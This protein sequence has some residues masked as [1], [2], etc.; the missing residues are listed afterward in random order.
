MPMNKRSIA[1]IIA[2]FFTVFTAFAVR[3]SYGML[4]PEM[5]PSLG[6]TKTQAGVIF[7]SYFVAYTVGSPVLGLL[8]DRYSV[9]FILTLFTAVLGAGTFLMAYTSS[10]LSASLFFTLAGI[11]HSACWAPVV[12]LVQRWVSDKRRGMALAFTDL[13]S[14]S[15][16]MLWSFAIPYIVSISSW[17]KGWMSLGTFAFIVALLNLL[18]I[19]NP[20]GA[21]SQAQESASV[22]PVHDSIIATYGRLLHDP[23]LW[24]LGISYLLVGF[25]VIIPFTFLCTFAT[26]ELHIAYDTST[27]LLAILAVAGMVGKLSLGYLSDIFGRA[28][29]MIICV[30]F[31]GSGCLGMAY[32]DGFFIL[33]IFTALFGLGYGSVWPIY[34]AAAPDYFPRRHSGSVIG[35][36]TLYLGAGSVVSPVLSG[37]TIDFTGTYKWAFI[38]GV[39]SA[40]ASL[41][42]L[43]PMIKKPP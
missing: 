24:I 14:A 43:I 38:I 7:A 25:T 23:N 30:V 1:V 9:R 40:I 4:L 3:Y 13:G 5:L 39:L 10:V 15:G 32:S 35:L 20:P 41:I 37:W 42:L 34:A 17:R 2:G 36:W 18:L 22:K 19:R 29:F 33:A 8:S 6:I 16:I 12:S 11:G 28:R 26:Q 27:R 21:A 31:L